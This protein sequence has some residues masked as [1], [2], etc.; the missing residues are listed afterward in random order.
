M[1]E[2]IRQLHEYYLSRGCNARDCSTKPGSGLGG[3]TCRCDMLKAN[4][5]KWER[6]YQAKAPPMEEWSGRDG[7]DVSS[8]RRAS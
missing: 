1:S 7:N 2:A 6:L 8:P 5:E 3:W 4:L